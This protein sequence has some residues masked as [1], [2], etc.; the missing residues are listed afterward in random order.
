MV[1]CMPEF[2]FTLMLDIWD[3][4]FKDHQQL[5]CCFDSAL[6][7]LLVNAM[8]AKAGREIRNGGKKPSPFDFSV[9]RS[10]DLPLNVVCDI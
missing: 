6:G 3:T 9:F 2:L 4:S 1:A 7:C 8:D 5:L 10:V